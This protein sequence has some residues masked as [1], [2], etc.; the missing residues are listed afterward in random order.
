MDNNKLDKDRKKIIKIQ[1]AVLSAGTLFAWANFS[2]EFLRWI[3][4]ETN[5]FSCTPAGQVANPFLTP[6]FYGAIFFTIAFVLSALIL[7]ESGEKN[8]S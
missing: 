6:C 4:N 5:S 1:F 3:N 8:E 7:K 2:V